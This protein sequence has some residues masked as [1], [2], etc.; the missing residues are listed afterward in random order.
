MPNHQFN[1]NESVP[2]FFKTT[3]DRVS[4][5]IGRGDAE[6]LSALLHTT[7]GRD[8]GAKLEEF[9]QAVQFALNDGIERLDVQRKEVTDA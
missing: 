6:V 2:D 3:P 8:A 9:I 4:L 7:E 1:I 5:S